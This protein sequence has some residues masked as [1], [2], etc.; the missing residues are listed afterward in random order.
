MDNGAVLVHCRGG[1]GRTGTLLAAYL[2]R[3]RG[4]SADESIAA[5]R[6]KRPHSIES[7]QQVESLR[8]LQNYLKSSQSPYKRLKSRLKNMFCQKL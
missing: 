5:V 6:A 3:F 1:N 2:M 4:L 7:W 8:A